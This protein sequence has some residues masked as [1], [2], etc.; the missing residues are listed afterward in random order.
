MSDLLVPEQPTRRS[1][2]AQVEHRRLLNEDPAYAAAR[3]QIETA[4]REFRRFL[5]RPGIRRIPVVVHVV[6]R[7]ETENISDEQIQSQIEVLNQDFRKTNADV[8]QVPAVWQSRVADARVEFALASTD[9]DGNPSNG[10]TRTQTNVAGFGMNG[11]PVKS[12]ATGGA[13]P[14]PSD[15]YLNMWVCQL[16]SNLLGY[17]Q[18]PGG[19]PET[20]GVVILHRGAAVRSGPYGDPRDRPLVEPVPYLGRRRDR[21]Q[22]HGRGRRH[23]QCRGGER[24]VPDFPTCDV[25]K[26]ARRRH[27][28]ELHGLHQ[29]C[30]H[31][32]V[33]RGTGNENAGRARWPPVVHRINRHG[34]DAGR[35]SRHPGITRVCR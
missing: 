12:A 33:H 29:R 2:G 32:H 28:H 30:L 18:F 7:T 35:G 20:D 14:W 23:P 1:C 25:F 24:G 27:V 15:Q 26:W 5:V 17:A 6:W 16:A 19:Q 3:S 34:A 4:A 31:V 9:P 13:D 21:L 22:R 8:G 11:N 10:V